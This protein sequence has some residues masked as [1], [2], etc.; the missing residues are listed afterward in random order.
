MFNEKKLKELVNILYTK[1]IVGKNIFEILHQYPELNIE[2]D[3]LAV[4]AYQYEVEIILKTNNP[5]T[6]KLVE[7]QIL[8]IN[9][10]AST[11]TEY[12]QSRIYFDDDGNL[13]QLF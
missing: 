11:L 6:R 3:K 10:L 9:S 4:M 8:V 5:A 13:T 2:C 7:E 12:R 1:E